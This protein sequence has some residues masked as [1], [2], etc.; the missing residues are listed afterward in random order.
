MITTSHLEAS[1]QTTKSLDHIPGESWSARTT[2]DLQINTP[3]RTNM[4]QKHKE[5]TG[6]AVTLSWVVAKTSSPLR[7]QVERIRCYTLNR[8]SNWCS[9]LFSFHWKVRSLN[10]L[11]SCQSSRSQNAS[12]AQENRRS[13]SLAGCKQTDNQIRQ[14]LHTDFLKSNYDGSVSLK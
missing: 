13:A 9:H 10:G 5:I 7:E 11:C 1:T 6:P 2:T 8:N 4:N 3:R 14:S 12:L